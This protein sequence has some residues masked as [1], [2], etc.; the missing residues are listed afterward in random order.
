M[1]GYKD[2]KVLAQLH[3]PPPPP[4]GQKTRC[5]DLGF[6][7]DQMLYCKSLFFREDFMLSSKEMQAF[8]MRLLLH[9]H[10]LHLP[11]CQ[12]KWYEMG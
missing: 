7:T 1:I 5:L 10:L 8:V 4:P 6:L 3:L 9:L 2:K 12:E 11:P